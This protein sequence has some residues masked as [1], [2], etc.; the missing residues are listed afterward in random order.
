MGMGQLENGLYTEQGMI[1]NQ[2]KQKYF[3]HRGWIRRHLHC[4]NI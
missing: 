1:Q 2:L 3:A 4:Q